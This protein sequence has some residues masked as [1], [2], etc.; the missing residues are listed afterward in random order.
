MNWL[1]ARHNRCRENR[2]AA[3]GLS[4]ADGDERFLNRLRTLVSSRSIDRVPVVS[5]ALGRDRDGI[6]LDTGY[7]R[8]ASGLAL[9]GHNLSL[10][11]H[12]RLK[13]S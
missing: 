10:L 11:R 13:H 1:F 3:H 6:H 7:K 5:D 4:K 8:T 12:F 2:T 9:S